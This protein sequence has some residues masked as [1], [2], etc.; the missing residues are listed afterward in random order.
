MMTTDGTER[1]KRE[2]ERDRSRIVESEGLQWAS[3]GTRLATSCSEIYSS[4]YHRQILT[5]GPLRTSC[6]CPDCRVCLIS[7]LSFVGVSSQGITFCIGNW[8]SHDHH[9]S[10]TG[11]ES[12]PHAGTVDGKNCTLSDG[13][14]SCESGQN[15]RMRNIM[16]CCEK[17]NECCVQKT[18]NSSIT[19][20]NKTIKI[21]Q[22]RLAELVSK[23]ISCHV[24]IRSRQVLT[25]LIFIKWHQLNMRRGISSTQFET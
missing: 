18:F 24:N 4:D 14:Y 9:L 25:E 3:H 17:W 12:T 5:V 15:L 2:R 10:V 22:G 20:F 6:Q 7:K 11:E 16:L 19:Y 1:G 21:R 13:F 8:I 23:D